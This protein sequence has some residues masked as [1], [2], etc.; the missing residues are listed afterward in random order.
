V[1]SWK[2]SR[3]VSVI[4]E[5]AVKA[6]L[7][8]IVLGILSVPAQAQSRELIGYAGVLGEWELTATVTETPSRRAG[9]FFGPVTMTHVG[10]CTQDGPEQKT[11]E[12]QVQVSAARLNATLSLAGRE[13]TYSA[14]LSDAYKGHLVCPDRPAVPLTLF[15]R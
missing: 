4:E 15:V 14:A 10:I 9:E 13:C 11:G 2:R 8:G 3:N 6:L 5:L 7:S 12:I 1:R